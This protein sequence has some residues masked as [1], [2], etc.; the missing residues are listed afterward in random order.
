MKLTYLFNS[1]FVIEC[2]QYMIVLDYYRDSP[3]EYMQQALASFQGKIY[4]L[5]S[6]WHPDHFNRV[7]MQWPQIHFDI[8]FIFSDDIRDNLKSMDFEGVDFLAKGEVWEDERVRIQAFGSTD[9][10]GSFLI[11]TDGKRIFHAGDLNNWHWNEEASPQEA[12]AAERDFLHELELLAKTTSQL[13]LAMFPVDPR[14]GKDYMLGAQQFVRR[15]STKFFS[16]MH[17][18][19][20]FAKAQAFKPFA[21]AAGC[22][23][24]C[25][26]KSGESFEI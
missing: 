15:I 20:E 4:V 11:D 16:P 6:H 2:E 24:I 13:D 19:D 18:G 14:L 5:A 9:V 7:V 12:Q 1:G 26:K 25:W 10:G 21:E 23:L 22:R 17:F 3:D 8:Q